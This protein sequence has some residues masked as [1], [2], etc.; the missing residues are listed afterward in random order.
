[1]HTVLIFYFKAVL[2][3]GGLP[4]LIPATADTAVIEA[5]FDRVSGVLF[6]GCAQDCPPAWYGETPEPETHIMGYPRADN[7]RMLMTLALQRA[8]PLLGICAGMQLYNVVSGGRLIQ[9]LRTPIRHTKVTPTEDACH[10]VMIDPDSRVASILGAG[11]CHVNS[12]H[13]QGVDLSRIAPGLKA[14]AWAPDGVI[15][16][17]EASVASD[18]FRLFV[19]WHPE[20]IDDEVHRGKLFS[21]FVAA[22][23]R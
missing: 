8:K 11:P 7:D 20:R 19:Q 2:Q 5:Y 14:T 18:L 22:C 21:A 9:H 3:A 17:L 10:E 15:E 4:V 16:A 12:S 13:H 1:M 6:T 23:H